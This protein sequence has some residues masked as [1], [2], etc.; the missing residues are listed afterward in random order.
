MTRRD[1]RAPA[2]LRPLR[3]TRGYLKHA[4]GSVLVEVGE[5]RVLCS[6]SVEDRVPPFLRG[7]GQGWVTAEYG[8]LPRATNTRT[9]REA[10]RIGGRTHEIQRLVGRSLRAVVELSK[11]GERTIT[12]DCDVIQADGG[13]RTA[14]ITGG[15]VAL[16]DCV[17]H[18]QS[19]G[20]LLQDPLRDRVAATSVGL[21]A[22]TPILDLDYSEDSTAEVDMNV[23]MTGAGRFVE[24]QGTA[25]QTPFDLDQLQGLLGL[26]RAG[27]ARLLELQRRV[28]AERPTTVF[29]LP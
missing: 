24:V 6:A 4:E 8:M 29:T 22:A 28:L 16:A 1:G 9:P 27:I 15:F 17:H 23:V 26:A 11:L 7:A 12:V 3:L 10:G 18:L 25:E 13:T 14:A 2:D 5:T 20:R 21:V 19:T